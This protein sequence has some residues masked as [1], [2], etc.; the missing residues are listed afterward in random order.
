LKLSVI[1]SGFIFVFPNTKHDAIE[2][3]VVPLFVQII[4]PKHPLFG[5]TYP[6]ANMM[7]PGRNWISVE[8][9]CGT[10]RVI[11][12]EATSLGQ[13]T[14]PLETL[15]KLPRISVPLMLQLQQLLDKQKR[16]KEQENE[17]IPRETEERNSTN[18]DAL[19]AIDAATTSANGGG[20]A[21]HSAA[22]AKTNASRGG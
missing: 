8:M 11:P 16:K 6:V 5:Q 4:D 19:A 17:R 10:K 1:V 12:P 14:L 7:T 13:A 18:K 15:L 20:D 21:A 3:Q 2:L 22:V 9:P